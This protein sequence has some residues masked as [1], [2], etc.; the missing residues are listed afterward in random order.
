MV[1]QRTT[2]NARQRQDDQLGNKRQTNP[3]SNRVAPGATT[4]AAG[5]GKS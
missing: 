4:S 2:Q 1:G 5:I 3:K